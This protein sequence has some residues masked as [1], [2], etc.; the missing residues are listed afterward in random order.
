VF[1]LAG[2]GVDQQCCWHAEPVTR[3]VLSVF[4]P[5]GVFHFFYLLAALKTSLAASLPFV[6]CLLS[7]RV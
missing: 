3:L 5:S 6:S 7:S 1:E 2:E 4:G